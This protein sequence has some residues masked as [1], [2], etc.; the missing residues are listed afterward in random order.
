MAP[1]DTS[2]RDYVFEQLA[3]LGVVRTRSMFG[4]YGVYR[5]EVFFAIISAGLLY[6]KTDTAN[7]GDYEQAGM[8]PFSPS[9]E[10]RLTSYYEVPIDVIEDS[11]R[12]VEWAR[13]AIMAQAEKP[14]TRR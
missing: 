9:A 5:G 3:E 4:G 8:K 10:Q 7:R 2:F 13:K 12:L 11:E 14:N 1:K 6:F